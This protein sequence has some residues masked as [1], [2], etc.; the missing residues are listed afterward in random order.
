V[1]L[2]TQPWKKIN[3]KKLEAVLAGRRS[4]WRNKGGQS[5]KQT[6]IPQKK[7]LKAL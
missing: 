3:V 5:L 1:G 4:R 2:T 7:K 6:V